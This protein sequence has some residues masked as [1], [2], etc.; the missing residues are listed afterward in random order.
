MGSERMSMNRM[1]DQEDEKDDS[2]IE[3]DS[4]FLYIRISVEDHHLQVRC[5]PSIEIIAFDRFA[6]SSLLESLEIPTR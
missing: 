3:Q 4:T 1:E 6:S 5:R 2:G